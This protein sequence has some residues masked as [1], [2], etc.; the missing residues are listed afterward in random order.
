MFS[1]ERD[2]NPTTSNKDRHG[3]PAADA[4]Q[5]VFVA[6]SL[7][8][9][10][11]I[12]L[13]YSFVFCLLLACT[14]FSQIAGNTNQYRLKG[15]VKSL[16]IETSK[17][18]VKDG[19]LTEGPRILSSEYSFNSRGQLVE[20]IVHNY[21]GSPYTKY[22]AI[23]VDMNK[24]EENYFKPKGELID[25]MVYSYTPDGKL[26]DKSVEKAKKSPTSKS[27]FNYDDKGRIIEKVHKNIEDTGGFRVVYA[28][29]DAQNRIEETAYDLKGAQTSRT[30]HRFDKQIRLIEKEVYP[31]A[32]PSL[33]KIS[34]V[35][36]A[37]DNISEETLNIH[38]GVGKWRYEYE[39]DS[40]GN[41][42]KRITYSLINNN[43]A[44]KF[45]PVEATH[46]TIRYDAVSN[47]SNLESPVDLASVVTIKE[48]N[49]YLSGDA[50]KRQRPRPISPDEAKGQRLTGK[51][52]VH[53]LMDETG[54]A[55]SVRA[56]PDRAQ[57]LRDAA[58]AAAWDWKFNPTVSGGIAIKF[59]RSATFNFIP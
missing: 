37:N 32:G 43:G 51:I 10:E 55:I 54:T 42:I 49:S 13:F 24:V 58:A 50:V 56:S 53:I 28:Y 44:L 59:I 27:I 39:A 41:W 47:G 35:Y 8:G 23:Y 6:I 2:S 9:N 15:P 4:G 57:L 14:A 19:K 26:A 25:R 33:W 11:M 45:E 29:D 20:S 34:F 48:T 40:H 36:D 21:D 12:K 5:V 3:N 17:I 46:R 1:D 31:N 52:I 18:T 16:R 22:Q 7:G 30:I 38:D